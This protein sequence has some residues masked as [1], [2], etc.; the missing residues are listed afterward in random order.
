MVIAGIL[1]IVTGHFR[2]SGLPRVFRLALI[3]WPSALILSALFGEFVSLEALLLSLFP[4]GWFLLVIALRPKPMYLAMAIVASCSLIAA[5]ALLQYLGLDPFHFIGWTRLTYQSPRMRVIGTLGN[6][7]FVAAV[8]VAGIPLSVHLG[9]LIKRQI[10]YYPMMIL[11][12]AAVFA[13]GSR[14]AVAALIASAVWLGI[15]GKFVRWRLMMAIA[16]L[17]VVLIPLMPSR[18]LISTLEGRCYI[19]QVTVPHVLDRPLLGFGPGAFE[20]KFIEWE[21]SYWRDGRGT[22]AQR[23]YTGLQ[24]HAHN[25]YIEILLNGGI[26]T[27]FSLWLLLG[28]FLANVFQ[29]ARHGCDDTLA[30]TSAGVVAMAAVAM[31]DFPFHRPTELFFLWTLMALAFSIKHSGSQKPLSPKEVT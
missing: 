30:G 9:K 11:Q 13:T 24:A 26:T 2:L 17:M 29:T 28:L 15:L 20:P 19:W 23:K 16:L 1:A 6:P 8:L 10:F 21:T 4:V 5:I 22:D 31:I 12:A 25:D 3:A 18:S 14:A 7:N 27:F